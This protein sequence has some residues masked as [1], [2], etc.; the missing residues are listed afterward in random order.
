MANESMRGTKTEEYVPRRLTI[1][2]TDENAVGYQRDRGELRPASTNTDTTLIRLHLEQNVIEAI[3]GIVP[4]SDQEMRSKIKLLAGIF[5]CRRRSLDFE[6]RGDPDQLELLLATLSN[7]EQVLIDRGLINYNL[8]Y[9]LFDD[10]R[11]NRSNLRGSVNNGEKM[12]YNPS[13][14]SSN[15]QK[16]SVFTKDTLVHLRTNQPVSEAYPDDGYRFIA[17]LSIIRRSNL[18]SIPSTEE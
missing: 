7:I 9:H 18:P 3:R 6:F 15:A 4:D 16:Q 1:R 10:T 17:H 11:V 2:Y 8:D 5:T 12:I 13:R 14:A